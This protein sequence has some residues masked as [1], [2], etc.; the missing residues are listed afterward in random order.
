MNLAAPDGRILAVNNALCEMLGYSEEE[1]LATDIQSATHP[2]D[3]DRDLANLRALLAGEIHSYQLEKR[4]VHKQG[5]P[6]EVLLSVSLIRD[7]DGEPLYSV[8]HIQDITERRRAEE[9]LREMKTVLD[10]M[11]AAAFLKS[12]DGQFRLINRKYEELYGVTFDSVRGRTLYDIHP[13]ELA[14]DYTR[15][16][17]ET[18][19][20]EEVIEREIMVEQDG[21]EHS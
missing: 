19:E 11:P 8:G 5:H 1:L 7:S 2:E 13:K 15:F 20:A 14:D 10:N 4:Y 17:R 16:D 9:A 12:L 6:I 3:L 21:E 18:I